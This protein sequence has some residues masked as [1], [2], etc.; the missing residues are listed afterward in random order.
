MKNLLLASVLTAAFGLSGASAAIIVNGD[1]TGAANG[2]LGF[3]TTVLGWSAPDYPTG[4]DFLWNGGTADT[5]GATGFFGNVTLWT[6]TPAPG[7]GAT[8]GGIA[9]FHDGPISQLVNLTP[10]RPV[11]ITFSWAGAQQKGFN[12]T[13]MVGWDVSLGSRTQATKLVEVPSHG[14]TGWQTASF[15]F[16]PTSSSEKLSFLAAGQGPDHEVFSLVSGVRA[17]QAVVPELSTWAMMLLGAAGLGYAGL[18]RARRESMP[19]LM[20]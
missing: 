1:F 19:R 2:E 12:G 4:Y 5:T 8:V 10:N 18:R 13:D 16:T 6:S 17:T 11:T 9:A 7:G 14:F 15:T 20:A 3:N